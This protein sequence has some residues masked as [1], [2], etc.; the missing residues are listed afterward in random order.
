[1]GRALADGRPA[2][3]WNPEPDRV[4]VLRAAAHRSLLL[5]NA[6]ERAMRRRSRR[7]RSPGPSSSI[8]P[9]AAVVRDDDRRSLGATAHVLRFFGQGRRP[10][11]DDSAGTVSNYSG[12]L[13]DGS[14]RAGR[15][16]RT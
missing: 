6:E 16:T 1:V 7:N 5:S 11:S 15:T 2:R 9:G 13:S 12:G 8:R 14:R 10:V 4:V 3:V